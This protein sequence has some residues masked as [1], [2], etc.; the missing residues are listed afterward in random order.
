LRKKT[1]AFSALFLVSAMLMLAPRARA[2]ASAGS[3]SALNG[4]VAIE[5][6]GRSIPGIYGTT[7]QVGDKLTTDANSRVTI[8]LSDGSQI[9][10]TE[11][12]TLVLTENT[13][14]PDGSRA[15]TKITLLGGL[16]RSFV[17]VAAG[18][19]PNFEVYTPNAVAAARGTK[20]DVAYEKGQARPVGP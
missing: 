16:V 11:S 6:A 5:R 2:Q 15:S 12:S 7:L 8:A 10:L 3:I 13:L 1:T 4:N 20:F 19:A 17:R 14:N 9:E 18:S